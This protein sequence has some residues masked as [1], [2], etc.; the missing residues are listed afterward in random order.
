[1]E[2]LVL[3]LAMRFSKILFLL[4]IIASVN[5]NA[6][7]KLSKGLYNRLVEIAEQSTESDESNVD[8]N[9][10]LENLEYYALHPINLNSASK[11]D[12]IGL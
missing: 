8:F 10:F 5:L 2:V 7:T 12:F 4:G 11:E 1:M 9:T 3:Q 6:Q